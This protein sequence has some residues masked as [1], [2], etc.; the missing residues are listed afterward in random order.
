MAGV[1][2]NRRILY[3]KKIIKESLIELLENKKIHQITVTDICKSAN[4]NRG[5]FY[6]HYKDAYDLL[7]SMED[8]LF[9]QI[10]L[11]GENESGEKLLQKY[12]D[13]REYLDYDIKISHENGDFTKFSKVNREKSGGETQTP[14]YVVI[15]SSFEQLI[16]NR[17]NEDSGCVVLFDEAFNNMD[18]TR[19]QAMMRFYNELNVQIILAAPPDRASTIMPYVDTTLAI[20]K[21][22]DNSFVEAIIHE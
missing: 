17:S 12:T 10:A 7:Q 19:I 21:S 9:N 11:L 18:E 22:G 16:K 1:K 3:T 5:S 2:G 14:F 20:I 6:T 13:Y 8:E 15:A 4:I